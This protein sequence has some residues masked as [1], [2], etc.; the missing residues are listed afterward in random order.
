[1][2]DLKFAGLELGESHSD[3]PRYDHSWCQ[4]QTP[5]LCMV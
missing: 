1:M 4:S 2:L 3:V 5:W